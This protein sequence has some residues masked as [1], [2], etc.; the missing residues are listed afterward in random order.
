VEADRLLEILRFAFVVIRARELTIRFVLTGQQKSREHAFR[1]KTRF[2]ALIPFC[3]FDR[4][5]PPLTYL[6][7]H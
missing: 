5:K 3:L 4:L 2:P 7:F 6:N 1:L